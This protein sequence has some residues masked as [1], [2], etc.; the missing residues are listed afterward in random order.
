MNSFIRYILTRGAMALGI[1]LMAGGCTSGSG[2]ER[3]DFEGDNSAERQFERGAKR[4]PTA[5]TLYSMARILQIQ[6]KDS[7][8]EFVLRRIVKEHPKFVP[9]YCGLAETLMRQ[10]RIDEAMGVLSAGIEIAPRD[11][12]LLNN[13]GMCKLLKTDYEAALA[14]FTK[15][16]AIDPNDTRFR[17][18]MAVSLGM[19]GR[20]KEAF[21]LYQ[22][23]LPLPDAHYNI[24]VIAQAR[25][26]H[27]RAAREYREAESLRAVAARH[28][29]PENSGPAGAGDIPERQESGAQ[30]VETLA[31]SSS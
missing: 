15:A 30:P 25:R 13:L 16:A 5:K 1:A 9:A 4:A 28:K 22:Q 8:A 2:G 3:T 23:V 11:A 27:A 20:Y 14:C 18:N 26:D 21:S 10:R 31:P 6:G 17:S 29:G 12:I 7:D 24:G 19:M